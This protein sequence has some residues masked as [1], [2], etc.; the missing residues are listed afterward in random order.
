MYHY[1]CKL[2]VVSGYD[3][4]NVRFCVKIAHFFCAFVRFCVRIVR[5]I[6]RILHIMYNERVLKVM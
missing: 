4:N 1:F 2:F 3:L 6:C 5:A